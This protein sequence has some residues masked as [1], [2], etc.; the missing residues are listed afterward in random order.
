MHKSL[1]QFSRSAE[2]FADSRC[3]LAGGVSSGM[4]AAARPLPLFFSS[5]SGSRLTDVDGNQY[6][7]YTLAWGPLI[8]GHSHP[9]ILSA[10]GA[11][12]KQCQL[13]GAQNELEVLVAKKI[14]QMVPCAERVA[15][16]TTGTE[17]VQIA[18][19][20]ARAFTGRR[21]IVRFEGHYHGW[22]DDALVG[23]R[24]SFNSS[25]HKPEAR[26]STN[27]NGN[28][29]DEMV[30]L[31]WNDLEE[32]EAALKNHGEQTAAIITE[33]I[34]CNSHCLLPAPG[35]LEGLRNLATRYGV[36]L[37]FDEVI[38]GFRVAPGG[39]QALFGV[40][41]D[42]ATFGKAVA[43]GFP[44]SVVAANREI[45]DLI[46]QRKVIH[47]G[48]F[49]GN[50]LSLAAACATLD[51]LDEDQGAVLKQIGRTGKSL[52]MGIEGLAQA[53]GIPVLINGVGAGFNVAFT[54]RREMLNYRDTLDSNNSA[55]DVFL[56]AMLASGIYLL[57][58]GR[59]YV[60]SAHTL[61]DVARTIDS[62]GKVLLKHKAKLMPV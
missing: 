45:M 49:N 28:A 5:G 37:I 40:K 44:F 2:L 30:V 18:F 13:L 26:L 31:Q 22:L 59:W 7:D 3:Y 16:S 8:L 1:A 46:E 14:C 29:A 60:S 54:T 53:A 39:A 23:Y 20:L 38:T 57:P 34:L 43:G 62:V 35:Y 15:F 55:R 41:P 47:A 10:V 17:A 42:I 61:E 4:R 48:T 11:Q 27:K 19:R 56:E 9:A 33:P 58:D 24:P 12:L 25:E 51:T 50:P 32:V 52:M 6:I 36:L 21:K